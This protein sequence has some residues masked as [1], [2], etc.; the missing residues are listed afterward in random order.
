MKSEKS[1][2]GMLIKFFEHRKAILRFVT[3][4]MIFAFIT[5]IIAIVF[6]LLGFEKIPTNLENKYLKIFK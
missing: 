2:S 4:I 5:L 6:E 3:K 1:I